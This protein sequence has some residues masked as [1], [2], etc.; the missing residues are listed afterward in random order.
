MS[1]L[2]LAGLTTVEGPGGRITLAVW[3]GSVALRLAVRLW[4]MSPSSPGISSV[5]ATIR[6]GTADPVDVRGVKS[7]VAPNSPGDS[8]TKSPVTPESAIGGAFM[9]AVAWGST[10]VPRSTVFGAGER[11]LPPRSAGVT[12]VMIDRSAIRARSVVTSPDRPMPKATPTERG[13]NGRSATP[14]NINLGTPI[15]PQATA[16]IKAPPI[17]DS[18]VRAPAT[19]LRNRPVDSE[20]PGRFYSRTST[21]SAVPDRINASTDEIPGDQQ[22]RVPTEPASLSATDPTRRPA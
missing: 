4:S 16:D 8:A 17:A 5:L 14:N 3:S 19:W 13:G 2:D 20:R 11:P 22:H 1:V 9:S 15:D 10:G 12:S 21:G 18:G 7:P 6:S